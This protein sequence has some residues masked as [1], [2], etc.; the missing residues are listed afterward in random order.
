MI[1][2]GCHKENIKTTASLL[3]DRWVSHKET[4]KLTN[5]FGKVVTYE[6]FAGQTMN[7][8]TLCIYFPVMIQKQESISTRT[9][10]E[11]FVRII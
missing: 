8:G 9:K 1:S 11:F 2:V 5:R 3:L 10:I 7:N 4:K 6:S